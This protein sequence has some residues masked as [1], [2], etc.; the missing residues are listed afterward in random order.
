[1]VEFKIKGIKTYKRKGKRYY[2]DRKTGKRL[3]SP[4]G[5]P[6]F[7]LE[8]Q[9]IR[10]ETTDEQA[11]VKKGTLKALIFDYQA[12]LEFAALA[13]RT[14][15]D[16]RG[17]ANDLERAGGLV[18]ADLK[19]PHITGIRDSIARKRTKDRA[20]RVRSF[21]SILF[22]WGIPHGHIAENP[23]A[24]VPS[25][26][27]SKKEKRK[28]ANRPWKEQEYRNFLDYTYP[29]MRTAI[30][31]AAATS[32]REQD[33]IRIPWSAVQDDWIIWVH[34]KNLEPIQV[35]ISDELKIVLDQSEKKAETIVMGIR[36][37]SYAGCDGFRTNFN[38]ERNRLA[39]LGLIGK[40]CTFHG[41]RHTI[42]TIIAD[43]GGS[44]SEIMAVS[45]HQS[46][47]QVKRYTKNARRKKGAKKAISRVNKREGA[48]NN[49]VV[50]SEG[51]KND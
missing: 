43:E 27:K 47:S 39:E 13:D 45:G 28:Q 23:A 25:L 6:E 10:E 24:V 11:R 30:A 2:Y 5:T 31:L 34:D 7:A 35:P 1:M 15:K 32:L 49:N 48:Q 37:R 19:A 50:K 40:D 18:L 16:Y 17:Y 8:V 33:V 44:E 38:K 51:M 42:L 14:Q 36:G 20:N 22:N 9:R 41:L 4:Y 29:E 3:H 12:S 26:K 21:L 46:E